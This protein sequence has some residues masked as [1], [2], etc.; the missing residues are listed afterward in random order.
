MQAPTHL[1][2]GVIIQ[3]LFDWKKY[4][5]VSFILVAVIAFLSHGIL[6]K[7]A[8]LTYHRPDAAPT[9]PFWLAFHL[10]VLLTTI[11]MLYVYWSTAKWGILFALLPDFD[12]IFIDGQ[13]AFHVEIPFYKTPYIH[14]FLHLIYDNLPP[15]SYIDMLPD[16]RYN[17]WACL[18]EVALIG[19]LLLL[20]RV[21]FNQRRNIHF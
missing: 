11:T 2:V 21:L 14:N 6:D 17:Y 10:V 20:I 12:W 5:A 19:L 18:V 9:D 3:K 7:L 16:W 15:F 8:R 13:A 4:R 1:L